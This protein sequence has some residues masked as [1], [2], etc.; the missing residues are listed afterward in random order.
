MWDRAVSAPPDQL[1][2]QPSLLRDLSGCHRPPLAAPPTLSANE[3]WK[4]AGLTV[5]A[6]SRLQMEERAQERVQRARSSVG[7]LAGLAERSP[8]PPFIVRA[9]SSVTDDLIS[10]EPSFTPRNMSMAI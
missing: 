4:A 9:S 5:K 7:S 10:E 6:V 3:R 1:A 8:A 2:R